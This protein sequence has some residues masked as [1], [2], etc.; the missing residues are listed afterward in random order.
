MKT[1][2]LA[3]TLMFPAATVWGQ[4]RYTVMPIDGV[5]GTGNQWTTWAYV[6]DKKESKLWQ[7]LAQIFQSGPPKGECFTVSSKVLRINENTEVRMSGKRAG[8]TDRTVLWFVDA[9]TG[10]VQFCGIGFV[11][12]SEKC[13]QFPSLP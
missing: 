3:V 1:I 4:E 12:E 2:L 6:I 7:C 10:L 13:F 11:R 9:N 5:M 8:D